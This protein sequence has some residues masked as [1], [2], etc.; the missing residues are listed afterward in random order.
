ML[1]WRPF[2]VSSSWHM[3]ICVESTVAIVTGIF[4]IKNIYSNKPLNQINLSN[5]IFIILDDH[6]DDHDDDET[7]VD[8]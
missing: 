3:Q 5:N 4:E 8:I 2:S 1:P 6:G 7:D